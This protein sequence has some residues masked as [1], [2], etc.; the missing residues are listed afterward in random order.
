[1]TAQQTDHAGLEILSFESCL[2]KLASVPVGRIGFVTAGE[3]IILPVNHVLVDERDLV[4]RTDAGTKLSSVGDLTPVTFETDEYN[5]AD[6]SGWSVVVHGLTEVVEDDAEVARLN[7][8]GVRPWGGGERPYWV[9]IRPLSVT[10]R[11]TLPSV[12]LPAD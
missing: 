12:T 8:I 1:M 11:Q 7:Q 3:V 4:F 5:E 9:R 2:R 6:E 10:G